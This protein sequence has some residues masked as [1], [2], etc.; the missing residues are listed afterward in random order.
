MLHKLV[1]FLILSGNVLAFPTTVLIARKQAGRSSKPGAQSPKKG[2]ADKPPKENAPSIKPVAQFPDIS[3]WR[4]FEPTTHCFKIKTPIPLRLSDNE[5]VIHKRGDT[6][7][8][9]FAWFGMSKDEQYAFR[10]IYTDR[11][12][13]EAGAIDLIEGQVEQGVEGELKTVQRIRW[14]GV[15]TIL[16]IHKDQNIFVF[17]MHFMIDSRLFEIDVITT[18][19]EE[20]IELAKQFQGSFQLTCQ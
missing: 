19:Y 10:I 18:H 20:G 15:A 11:P 1:L 3:E 17:G 2:E 6:M 8:H 4:Y 7:P 16:S 14:N 9:Y 12:Q 5:P 13:R